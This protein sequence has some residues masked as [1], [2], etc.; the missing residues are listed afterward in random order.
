MSQASPSHDVG[1]DIDRFMQM[2]RGEE[3]EEEEEG[4]EDDEEED[5]D[6]HDTA[7]EDTEYMEAME[8]QLSEAG[9]SGNMLGS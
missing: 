9:V 4:E 7:N 6:E 1:M 3:E 2:L 5:G 8:A